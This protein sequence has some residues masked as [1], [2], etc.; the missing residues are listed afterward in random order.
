MSQCRPDMLNAKADSFAEHSRRDLSQAATSY[1]CVSAGGALAAPGQQPL[2]R[3]V[4]PDKTA[5]QNG[6]RLLVLS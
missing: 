1:V 4:K 3:A 5:K 6:C 2:R